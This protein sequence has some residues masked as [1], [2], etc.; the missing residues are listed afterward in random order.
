MK[1]SSYY[2]ITC[3]CYCLRLNPF[4]ITCEIYFIY[5]F[6]E[7]FEKN[8][9]KTHRFHVFVAYINR[10]LNKRPYPVNIFFAFL[11]AA[12]HCYDALLSRCKVKPWVWKS[13][14]RNALL[15]KWKSDLYGNSDFWRWVFKVFKSSRKPA[16]KSC[17]ENFRFLSKYYILSTN[18]MAFERTVT[19]RKFLISCYQI[20]C[21]HT[22]VTQWMHACACK[23][24]YFCI[25]VNLS[26]VLSLSLL[27]FFF[28]FLT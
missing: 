22:I 4:F 25:P 10:C 2:I 5:I 8:V 20:W 23:T 26:I 24:P 19:L 14:H 12:E 21:T 17:L 15:C 9:K 3:N 1:C 13:N 27:L 18:K 11:K 16:E 7:N 28:S 6:Y